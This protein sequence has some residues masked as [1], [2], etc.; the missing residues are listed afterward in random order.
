MK[1]IWPLFILSL[2]QATALAKNTELLLTKQGLGPI[3]GNSKLDVKAIKQLLPNYDVNLKSYEQDG[4]TLKA[5]EVS[6]GGALLFVLSEDIN[7]EKPGLI[8][9]ITVHNSQI[10]DSYGL[11]I[12]DSYQKILRKRKNLQHQRDDH[13]HSYLGDPQDPIYYELHWEYSK[14][15]QGPDRETLTPEELKATTI[16][17]LVWTAR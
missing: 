12:G 11:K 17:S 7:Q 3:K 14:D 6:K 8:G 4:P 15:Y 13:Y 1:K 2:T 10:K 9:K 16:E 5:I